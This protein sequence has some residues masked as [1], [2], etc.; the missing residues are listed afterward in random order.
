MELKQVLIAAFALLVLPV[1]VMADLCALGSTEIEGNYFCQAVDSIQYSNVGTPGTF[2]R[3]VYMGADGTCHSV[4][5]SF[6][7]PNAPL[8]GEVSFHVRGPAQLK[9]FAVYIPSSSTNSA[10]KRGNTGITDSQVAHQ[11][12]HVHKGVSGHG[13]GHNHIE[14]KE[15][16]D[17]QEVSATI[18]GKVVSWGNNYFG[19]SSTPASEVMVTATI[20][21]QI[22]SWTNNWFGSSTTAPTSQA[23]TT[24]RANDPA[25]PLPVENSIPANSPMTPPG[26][27][28]S[29]TVHFSSPPTSPSVSTSSSSVLAELPS[30]PGFEAPGTFDRLSYYHA[31]SQSVENVTFLGNFGGEGSGVFDYHF[32]ASLSYIN[33]TGTGGAASSQILANQV[34]PSGHEVIIM[35]GRECQNGD[36]GYTRPGAVAYHGF[37]GADKV[38]MFDFSMPI[39]GESGFNGDLPAIWLLYGDIVRTLQYGKPECSCWS[40]G[41]G[42]FDIAEALLDGSTYLKSTLHTNTPAGDSDYLKRPT[43]SSMKLAVIFSSSTSTIRI[44]VLNESTEFAAAISAEDINVMCDESSDKVSHFHVAS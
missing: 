10:S 28:A 30:G 29:N 4:P 34:I 23:A 2:N 9:E 25:P 21:G 41:C 13:H 33:S 3:V 12:R 8:S 11:H 19:P 27:Q 1:L 15:V 18:D 39:D 43:T 6:A 7:G 31:A 14:A 37:D 38:F 36:C 20:D 35:S 22:V 17:R 32:G 16:N 24:A 44:Q 5:Q 42:E 40:S 26:S